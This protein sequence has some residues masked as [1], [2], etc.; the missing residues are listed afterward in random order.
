MN[1]RFLAATRAVL[2]AAIAVTGFI[3][4]NAQLITKG[5]QYLHAAS[6]SLADYLAERQVKKAWDAYD[7]SLKM[8]DLLRAQASA[9]YDRF[10]A[11]SDVR[12]SVNAG[13]IAERVNLG[14]A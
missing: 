8:I 7:S 2:T 11:V 9:D 3:T 12:D 6:L 5:A 14:I 10:N 13:T 4:R 1:N